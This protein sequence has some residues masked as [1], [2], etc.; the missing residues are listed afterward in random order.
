MRPFLYP[1][2]HSY[3]EAPT[4]ESKTLDIWSN[5]RGCPIGTVP[6]RRASKYDHIKSKLSKPSSFTPTISGQ[7][8]SID[9]MYV[10]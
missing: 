8:V 3:N 9:H 5:G 7:V 4:K 2:G 6:I 10:Q 1:K